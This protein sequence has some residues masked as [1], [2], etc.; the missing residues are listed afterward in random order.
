[1]KI[2]IGKMKWIHLKSDVLLTPNQK[3][4]IFGSLLGDATM[5][6]GKGAVNANFKI[7]IN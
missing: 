4:I 1:M 7:E 3:S 6:L 2:S 5:R